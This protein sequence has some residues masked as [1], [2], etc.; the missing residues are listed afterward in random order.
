MIGPEILKHCKFFSRMRDEHLKEIVNMITPCK[1]YLEGE[2]ILR[3]GIPMD[4]IY[5]IADGRVERKGMGFS[6][7]P[8]FVNQG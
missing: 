4:F 2:Q 7:R 3:P 5:I 8:L 6:A 1:V